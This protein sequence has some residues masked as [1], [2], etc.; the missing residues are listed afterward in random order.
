MLSQFPE[1]RSKA[2]LL[3]LAALILSLPYERIVFSAGPFSFSTIELCCGLLFAA[4]CAFG[5][6]ERQVLFRR[7]LA[8]A[9]CFILALFLSA[10][11][12]KAYRA[13]AL[14]FSLRMLAGFVLAW[15]IASL[16]LCDKRWRGIV[17]SLFSI[18]GGLA[19][20][21]GL[22]EWGLPRRMDQWYWS[23][24]TQPHWI[25]GL[26]RLTG[27]F[28][29]PNIAAS[30]FLFA[31]AASIAIGLS[32]KKFYR[33]IS[34]LILFALILTYSRGA[35]VAATL[36]L[37]VAAI[38]D[39]RGRR[40]RQEM[41]VW[42]AMLVSLSALALWITPRLV[43]RVRSEGDTAWLSA[44]YE[45]LSR[46]NS[47]EA[48]RIYFFSLRVKN[49]GAAAWDETLPVRLSYHWYDAKTLQMIVRD[50]MRTPLPGT[51]SPGQSVVVDAAVKTPAR[52]GDFILAFDMVQEQFAWFSERGAAPALIRYQVGSAEGAPPTVLENKIKG[53]VDRGFTVTGRLDLWRAAWRLFLENK[54][55]GV[56]PDNYRFEYERVLDRPTHFTTIFANNLFLEILA[57]AGVIGFAALAGFLY[58]LLRKL[59]NAGMAARVALVAFLVHGMVD[60]FLEF[61]P[62]YI[63]FWIFVGLVASTAEKDARRD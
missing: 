58:L 53:I 28:E 44:S 59:P 55:I 26:K 2:I 43:H 47:L 22:V 63:S 18:T 42:V 56:G 27:T 61:S 45:I 25:G 7:L 9:F 50:G 40:V 32:G 12:Q 35:M 5:R 37:V 39:S 30:F 62:I 16:V 10:L 4:F 6:F 49:E 38:L 36:S 34:L 15:V 24:G 33:G 3:T 29:Y 31:L 54:W 57:D 19:A 48:D 8:A 46:P 52:Q 17:L 60:Y 1:A 23:L 41:M 14:K 51:I 13:N 21:L 20:V 11:L